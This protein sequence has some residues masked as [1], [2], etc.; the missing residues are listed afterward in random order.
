MSARMTSAQAPPRLRK[1]HRRWVLRPALVSFFLF[2]APRPPLRRADCSDEPSCSRSEVLLILGGS[3]AD[4]RTPPVLPAC[5]NYRTSTRMRRDIS[6][7]H[8]LT[9]SLLFCGLSLSACCSCDVYSKCNTSPTLHTGSVS[10]RVG[11]VCV[12]GVNHTIDWQ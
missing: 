6:W 7:D 3:A 5:K 8:I 4:V 10:P 12:G 9:L 11:G 1:K 2:F